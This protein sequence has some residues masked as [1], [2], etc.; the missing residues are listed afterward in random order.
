LRICPKLRPGV[1]ER[2]DSDED[3]G[4]SMG[5]AR[6]RC[7]VRVRRV[8]TGQ[9]LTALTLRRATGAQEPAG[10][11]TRKKQEMWN[12]SGI[13]ALNRTQP[14]PAASASITLTHEM[15]EEAPLYALR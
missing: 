6:A 3:G 14:F 4:V 7:P 12:G 13:H 11:D 2:A 8:D 1:G 9:S 10:G 15:I 5:Q